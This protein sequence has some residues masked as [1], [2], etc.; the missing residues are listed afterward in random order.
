[1]KYLSLFAGIGGFELGLPE[2]WECVGY[3]EVKPTALSVYASHFP[4]H[5]CLGD[6]RTITRETLAAA[7][8]DV[9]VGG[10]P[11]TNL[12]SMAAFSPHTEATGVSA[13]A[14]RKSSLFH[15]FV[16]ILRLCA[17]AHFIFENSASMSRKNRDLISSLLSSATGHPVHVARIDAAAFTAQSRRR[18]FWTSFACAAPPRA[19]EGPRLASVLDADVETRLCVSRRTV[20]HTYNGTRSLIKG[21]VRN[22][23]VV[24]A[25]RAGTTRDG[26]PLWRFVAAPDLPDDACTRWHTGSHSDS[27]PGPYPWAYPDG[28]ARPLTAAHVGDIQSAL[29]DRRFGAPGTFLVRHFSPAELERLMGFPADW[30]ATVATSLRKDL[31]GNAVVPAAVAHVAKALLP[32]A[33]RPK[34]GVLLHHEE[35]TGEPGGWL[36]K[37]ERRRARRRARRPARRR[38]FRHRPR[39]PSAHA[40]RASRLQKSGRANETS[41]VARTR[42][43]GKRGA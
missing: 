26:L 17:G 39:P 14:N 15:E 38:G 30:T 18:L 6:V 25:V 11:C 7:A 43:V 37:S 13:A 10:S 32:R 9:I 36:R 27:G 42:E 41:R 19:L 21:S 34:S 8:P 35:E 29:L 20:E 1:M 12:T 16:R 5:R 3:A 23:R 31:L 24:K 4:A 33:P 28:K 2:G 40:K 22:G